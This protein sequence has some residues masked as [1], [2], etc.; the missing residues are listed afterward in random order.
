MINNAVAA[1]KAKYVIC[2]GN[3]GFYDDDSKDSIPDS[4]LQRPMSRGTKPLHRR[5]TSNSPHL[6]MAGLLPER[7]NM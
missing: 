4:N 1:T 2:T 3:F 7:S 5:G 6:V